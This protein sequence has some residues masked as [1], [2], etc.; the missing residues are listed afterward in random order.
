MSLLVQNPLGETLKHGLKGG[1]EEIQVR[2]M[3]G[4]WCPVAVL[5][6]ALFLCVRFV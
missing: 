2:G 3:S 1:A 5:A 6:G 4:W